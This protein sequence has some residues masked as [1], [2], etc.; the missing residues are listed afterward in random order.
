MSTPTIEQIT[1]NPSELLDPEVLADINSFAETNKTEYKA[2][3]PDSEDDHFMD[4]KIYSL[5]LKRLLNQKYPDLN[6]KFL[7]VCTD[8]ED[9]KL[10]G[11]IP[12][13]AV[14]CSLCITELGIVIEPQ[15]AR[16]MWI[17]DSKTP[18]ATEYYKKGLESEAVFYMTT[19]HVS[20][21]KIGAQN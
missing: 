11:K 6:I 12:K 20:L 13:H 10:L 8:F 14:H 5:K 16:I 15:T 3:D 4:C 19:D 1:D 21:P 18:S 7:L 2:Y 17:D 9:D